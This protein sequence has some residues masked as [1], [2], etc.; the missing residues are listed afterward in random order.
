MNRRR[1]ELNTLSNYDN[2]MIRS[3]FH[4]LDK[5]KIKQQF[6]PTSNAVGK[7]INNFFCPF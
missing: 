4:S 2:K 5:S 7:T 1:S 6:K 3:I